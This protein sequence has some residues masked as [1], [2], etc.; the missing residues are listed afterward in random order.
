V[1]AS[2]AGNGDPFA[3]LLGARAAHDV[4]GGIELVQV[5]RQTYGSVVTSES[6]DDR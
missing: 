3:A 1:A 2:L 6:E 4:N 5:P